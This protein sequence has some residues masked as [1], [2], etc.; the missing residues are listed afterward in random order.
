MKLRMTDYGIGHMAG[1][2]CFAEAPG[3]RIK[4]VKK[5]GQ[6][7]I[8]RRSYVVKYNC[9]DDLKCTCNVLETC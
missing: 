3:K 9:V 7:V 1:P 2:N 5:E 6:N 8:R 4:W